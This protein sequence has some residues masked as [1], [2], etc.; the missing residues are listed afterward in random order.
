[1]VDRFPKYVFFIATKMPYNT[2]QV[3]KLFF[4]HIVK[5]WGLPLNI[6]SD[7][8]VRLTSKFWTTLFKIMWMNLLNISSYIMQKYGH[9]E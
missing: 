7:R 8:V 9:I 6:V 5:Y 4:K 3:A 2:K 1:M